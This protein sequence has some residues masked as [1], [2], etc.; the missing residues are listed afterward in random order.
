[1]EFSADARAILERPLLAV[2]ATTR[3]DGSPHSVPVWFRFDG[4]K[5]RIWTGE[6]FGWGKNARARPHVALTVCDSTDHFSG[7]VLVRGTASFASGDEPSI[8][9]EIRRIAGRYLEPDRV[10]P[11]LARFPHLRTIATIEPAYVQAWATAE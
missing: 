1:M 3:D 6:D 9:E 10:E 5:I 11:Y 8:N 4:E 7:A 2:V